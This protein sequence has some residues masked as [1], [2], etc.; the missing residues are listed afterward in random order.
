[1][2]NRD[3]YCILDERSNPVPEP[4]L[5]KWIDWM[6]NDDNKIL[7][8]TTFK[9]GDQTIV[10][11]SM[12]SGLNEQNPF[13]VLADGGRF[14]GCKWNCATAKRALEMHEE[15]VK[16]S[17]E[18][19]RNNETAAQYSTRKMNQEDREWANEHKQD[20]RDRQERYTEDY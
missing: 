3:V 16:E 11:T 15:M 2:D 13:S 14:D 17:T 4:D 7:K 5:I 18:S 12:F 9:D 10:V 8:R 6:S 19:F 1:V 20:L